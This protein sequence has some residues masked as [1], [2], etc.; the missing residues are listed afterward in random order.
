LGGQAEKPVQ[1]TH[2]STAM[3][4][5]ARLQISRRLRLG[6]V[7]F[8]LTAA[9]AHAQPV[10]RCEVT[11]A[12]TTHVIQATPTTDPYA[13][14]PVDIAERFLFKVVLSATEKQLDHALIYVYLQQAPRPVLLQQAKYFGPFKSSKH[15][16]LLTG[17]QHVY[18]G[19]IERE[20]IYQC[21]LSGIKP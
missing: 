9:V 5:T 8:F 17:E 11:Y 3:Q 7:S 14:E 2:P 21:W 20:L 12:G 19:P 10:L 6:W 16:Y 15:A 1:L 18:G 4:L 13:V